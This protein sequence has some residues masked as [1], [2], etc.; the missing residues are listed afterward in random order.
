MLSGKC[1]PTIQP[2]L[3]FNRCL[4][5]IVSIY[6]IVYTIVVR[7]GTIVVI[8][9]SILFDFFPRQTDTVYRIR[10]IWSCSESR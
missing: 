6:M 10:R 1:T 5:R 7:S 4:G 2:P 8:L 3:I 9:F